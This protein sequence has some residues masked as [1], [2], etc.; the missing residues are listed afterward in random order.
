MDIAVRYSSTMAHRIFSL[1]YFKI[2]KSRAS[3]FLTEE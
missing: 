2:A 1:I 3:I